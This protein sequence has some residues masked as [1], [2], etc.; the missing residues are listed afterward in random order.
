MFCCVLQGFKSEISGCFW[1]ICE[2]SLFKD[3]GWKCSPVAS[4][5]QVEN[6]K[7]KKQATFKG[8]LLIVFKYIKFINRHP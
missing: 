1:G 4:H 5:E 2:S 6:A 8:C 3:Q 7:E